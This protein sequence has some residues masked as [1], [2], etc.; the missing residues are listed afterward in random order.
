MLYDRST[1]KLVKWLKEK[2]QEP[3][4]HD[5]RK[6]WSGSAKGM[7]PDMVA[8]MVQKAKDRGVNVKTLIGD[9][10]S[11]T[12]ARV[13]ANVDKD[14]TKE[15]DSNYIKQ[16]VSNTLH[17]LR[18]VHKGLSLKIISYLKKRFNYMLCDGKGK[19]DFIKE[20]LKAIPNDVFENHDYC[21]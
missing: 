2:K 13:K 18:N 6:N 4:D 11:T 3:P 20:G 10:D 9:E 5:C 12:I 19:S 1:A 15:S 16:I 17:S 8:E 7:E 21:G 14:I